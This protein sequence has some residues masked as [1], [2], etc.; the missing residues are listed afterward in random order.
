MRIAIT[1][2]AGFVGSSLTDRL[3]NSGHS[4]DVVDNF[5]TGRHENLADHERL[6]V[7]EASIA[8]PTWDLSCAPDVIVHAA[9]SYKDPDAWQEDV[10][11]NTLGTANV[12][13]AAE[14][15]GC[16]R[17]IYFQTALCYGTTPTEQPVTLA[18]PVRPDSSYA[19]S[20][21]AGE[22]YIQLS[23]L[24]FVSFRLANCYGPRNL[25]G[26]LP[27][28][29]KRLTNDEPVFVMDTRRD[30]VFID[31]LLDIVMQAIAGRGHGIYHVST[32]RDFAIKELYDAVASE[33]G[34]VR[35]VPVTPRAHDDAPT[36]LLDPSRAH[37]D[38]EWRATTGLRAGVR[39][40]VAYYVEHGV[41]RTFTHLKVP[42]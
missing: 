11:T 13:A 39:A 10:L 28:F 21:T 37:G 16:D 18:H 6:T 35:E 24:D 42:V 20:K 34:I 25:S 17:L 12:I 14:R 7:T 8:D 19:I 26:P 15:S 5:A 1:G 41:E 40:A 27:T 38:F 23:G 4:V 32:G 22:Q 33:L 9:A 30:F 3:L 29:Y 2:G 36:I 31:D